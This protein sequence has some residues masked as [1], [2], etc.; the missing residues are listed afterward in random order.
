MVDRRALIPR[1]ETEL[2]VE[3]ALALPAGTRVLDVGTGCGAVALALA[4]E[5][6]DLLVS[7]SDVSTEALALAR[8]NARRLRLAVR[9]LHADLLDGVSDEFDALVILGAGEALTAGYS[10]MALAETLSALGDTDG[11]LGLWQTVTQN[12]SY[13]RAKVQLAELYLARNQTELARG[14]L[15]DVIAD[16]R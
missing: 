7:A 6:P 1:P 5:R 15:Q 2:L 9:F 14:E 12:H 3:V 11:A 16:D 8:A 13:P 10:Q 4:H